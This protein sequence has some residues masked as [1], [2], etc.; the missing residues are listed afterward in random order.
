MALAARAGM[1][2]TRTRV[3]LRREESRRRRRRIEV[4]QRRRQ[5]ARER[6]DALSRGRGDGDGR[7][8]DG[9]DGQRAEDNRG[10]VVVAMAPE[11]RNGALPVR[12]LSLVLQTSAVGAAAFP[13]LH[14]AL[15]QVRFL[16]AERAQDRT[17]RGSQR[18][19]RGQR[20][21]HRVTARHAQQA[22]NRGR[23]ASGEAHGAFLPP[24]RVF[25]KDARCRARR[26]PGDYGAIFLASSS[27]CATERWNAGRWAMRSM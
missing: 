21:E 24:G 12:Q 25:G 10:L 1:A 20:R 18:G 19:G 6:G 8:G 11:G 23:Q 5:R 22:A 15:A 27:S 2:H 4:A 17:E 14:A 9:G 13:G 3:G 7:R 16:R 26:E